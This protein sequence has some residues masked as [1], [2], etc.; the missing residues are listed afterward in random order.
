ME[1]E[2]FV[3]VYVRRNRGPYSGLM[4]QS[5]YRILRGVVIIIVVVGFLLM[6]DPLV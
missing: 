3:P 1:E 4:L 2:E 5:I 6:F